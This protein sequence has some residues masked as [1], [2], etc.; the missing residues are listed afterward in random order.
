MM[1]PPIGSDRFAFDTEDGAQYQ[2][3]DIAPHPDE[4]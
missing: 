4:E 1:P 3:F 2:G